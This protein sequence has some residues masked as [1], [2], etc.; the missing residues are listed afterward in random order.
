[1]LPPKAEPLLLSGEPGVGKSALLDAAAEVA[2]EAGTRV[3]CAAGVEFEAD[4]TFSGLHQVPLPL[5]EEFGQ[6]SA[7]HRDALTVA[8]G[9]GAGPAPDRLVV[10]NA[11]LTDRYCA[12]HPIALKTATGSR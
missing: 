5:H 9:F 1:M 7:T 8:L 10:S 2:S 12:G 4:M 6:L 3:L 11:A